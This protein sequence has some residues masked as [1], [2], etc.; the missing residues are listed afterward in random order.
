MKHRFCVKHDKN[1][2]VILYPDYSSCGMWCGNCGIEY[3]NPSS[4]FTQLPSELIQRV[5]D[6]VLF[7]DVLQESTVKLVCCN[8][9][10]IRS[11]IALSKEINSYGVE[12][13]FDKTIMPITEQMRVRRKVNSENLLK[14]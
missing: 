5:N 10:I 1:S 3:G 8:E 2:P 13:E 11:G 7:W 6:W 4:Y 14:A 12:C 9:A